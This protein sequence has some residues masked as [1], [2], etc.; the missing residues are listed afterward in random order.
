M[1]DGSAACL[2]LFQCFQQPCSLFIKRGEGILKD[3]SVCIAGFIFPLNQFFLLL[4]AK[5]TFKLSHD[6]RR[7]L[8]AGVSLPRKKK[9]GVL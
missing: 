2:M 4:K 7:G 8:N 5:K 9:V 1:C 6:L 3:R